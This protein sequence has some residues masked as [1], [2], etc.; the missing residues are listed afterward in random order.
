MGHQN[1][2]WTDVVDVFS[3]LILLCLHWQVTY[4]LRPLIS[5]LLLTF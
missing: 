4:A 5:F 3:H 1:K 2:F